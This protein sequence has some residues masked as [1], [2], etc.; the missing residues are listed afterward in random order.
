M[1]SARRTSARKSL[2]VACQSWP[3]VSPHVAG[4]RPGRNNEDH[5]HEQ[6]ADPRA[7]IQDGPLAGAASVSCTVFQRSVLPALRI[8]GAPS[9]RRGFP[10]GA[11]IRSVER[12]QYENMRISSGQSEYRQ[13]FNRHALVCDEDRASSPQPDTGGGN[14]SSAPVAS[15]IFRG[16]KISSTIDH[17]RR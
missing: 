16:E 1:L 7:R 15:F 4:Q 2:P 12:I 14:A 3:V 6:R 17:R 5:R 11:L 13:F 10:A 8:A 9:S